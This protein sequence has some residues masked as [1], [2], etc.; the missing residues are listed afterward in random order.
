MN[1]KYGL[2]TS[3]IN[4]QNRLIT[5]LRVKIEELNFEIAKKGQI[6]ES[7]RHEKLN[8]PQNQ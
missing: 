6:I 1:A 4:C 8:N 7:L 2:L 3:E 5:D